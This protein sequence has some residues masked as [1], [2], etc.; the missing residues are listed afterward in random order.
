MSATA[1][2][3]EIDPKAAAWLR[4]LIRRDLIAP[5]DVDERSIEDVTPNDLQPYTQCHFFAGIGVWSYALRLAEWPDD[6][7][8]WTGSC[9]C[10]PFSA[11]GKGG[12]FADERHLWPA[13]LHLIR[14]RRPGIW[15]GEQVASKDGLGWLDLVQADLE[16]E[17]YAVGAVDTCSA[18]F[19]APHIRQRLRIA[20]HR[21]ADTD[22]ARPHFVE[23]DAGVARPP[24]S[25]NI[26]QA[27][28]RSDR[29]SVHGYGARPT[30]GFW[31]D[32]DWL[33]CR[34]GKWRP[35]EPGTFPLAHGA[36]ARVGFVC[37]ECVQADEKNQNRQ[38]LSAVREVLGSADRSVQEEVLQPI[39]HGRSVH[40]D[41][42][43]QRSGPLPSTAHVQSGGMRGLWTA[44]AVPPQAPQGREPDK[45]H[46]LKHFDIVREMSLE[47][48]CE[49]ACACCGK[50]S[51]WLADATLRGN[52][53]ARL[54]G[55]GNAVD[56]IATKEFILAVSQEVCPHVSVVL[57][58]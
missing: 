1:Y 42:N 55:Y 29:P 2:Y 18:G 31:R 10:Q 13:M 35:V 53:V 41:A 32:A 49:A 27:A 14:E 5:G 52:R 33:F 43:D 50:Q 8:V 28:V 20:A 34:D 3:N 12:G 30:D 37:A 19:G 48:T 57:P 40:K 46:A 9:P 47:G 54:R 44:G 11:A 56:A 51:D 26:R 39:L 38:D 25:D 58:D 4:E 16:G 7:P 6:Q 17:G 21:V 15:L 45:Q 36:P 23:R 24:G 22:S